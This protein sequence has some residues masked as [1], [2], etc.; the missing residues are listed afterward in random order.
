MG[1]A[2][3]RLRHVGNPNLDSEIH[4]T[5]ELGFENMF[6]GSHVNGSIYYNDVSDYITTYRVSDGTYDNTVNDARVYKN[7]DA[8]IWG[9]ELTARKNIT[10][11]VKTTLNLNYTH[12]DDD[13]Q[14]RP[15]PQIMPL[16]GDI[17][18][19]YQTGS[20]N[21]GIRANFADT[22]DNF[23]SR[24]LDSGRTGGYTVYDIYAGFEPTPNIRFSMGVSNLTDKRYAT[25]LNSTNSIDSTA[26]RVDEPGRS[27]WGSLIYDF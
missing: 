7:V 18:L 8:T 10:S 6:M 23:D 16:S 22:Q 25:H 24:V 3:Y 15:L 5:F 12:G 2:K 17:S 26:D 19:E 4:T 21:Y 1:G 9:Y 13:T 14:N 27:F 11:N 20:I